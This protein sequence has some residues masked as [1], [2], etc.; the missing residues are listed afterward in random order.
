MQHVI[1]TRHLVRNDSYL[2]GSSV[3]ALIRKFMLWCEEQ[4]K[5]RFF[6]MGLALMGGIGTVLPITLL[7]IVFGADNNCTLWV[8]A[9]AVNVP[10]LILN[11]AAL[12]PKY[13]LPTLFFAWLM[14]AIIIAYCLVVYVL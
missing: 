8:L 6:W 13:T 1:S 7:A 14:D 4:E 11:L 9:C 3:M 12:P 5:N 2:S 10:I